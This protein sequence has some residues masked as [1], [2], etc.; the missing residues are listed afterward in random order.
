[1]TDQQ[2][3]N[4]GNSAGI[5]PQLTGGQPTPPLEASNQL[6]VDDSTMVD[7]DE[8]D[9]KPMI[10]PSAAPLR[11]KSTRQQRSRRNS[12]DADV[13]RSNSR[14][15]SVSRRGSMANT[16]AGDPSSRRK[17]SSAS[18][19]QT[20]SVVMS[21]AQLVGAST[22]LVTKEPVVA[23]NVITALSA[24]SSASSRTHLANNAA[25]QLELLVL[26]VPIAGAKSR[27]ETQIKIS[28][29]LVR[30]RSKKPQPTNSASEAE[31]ELAG[32]KFMTLDGALEPSA[33]KEYERIGA[34][35]HIRLPSV[36]ALK[37]KAKKQTKP[38]EHGRERHLSHSRPRKLTRHFVTLSDPAAADTLTLEVSVNRGSEPYD[39]IF[40]C[41]GCQARE[42][43]RAQ[44]KKDSQQ[45]QQAQAQGE[46]ST[47]SS[48]LDERRKVVV[49]NTPEYVEFST[50]EVVL[51]TRI[52]CY[53]RHH[54]ERKGFA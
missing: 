19:A 45:N 47:V 5:A 37:K 25:G 27:V 38:G 10:I 36:L 53:C 22:N 12:N 23:S 3:D 11:P 49:F 1:M 50:G 42:H 2:F 15:N 28:L 46:S 54:K 51:P 52:T 24:T 18:G 26:G 14:E 44:R 40:I 20:P 9:V 35:T 32:Q 21:Q 30:N 6:P 29:V 48:E 4:S 31:G 13:S 8:A 16:A 7:Q 34:W 43:K 41:D 17:K 39:E 33:G